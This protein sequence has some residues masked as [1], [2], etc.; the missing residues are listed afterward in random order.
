VENGRQN[1]RK[2][3]IVKNQKDSLKNNIA[4]MEEEKPASEECNIG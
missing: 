2:V 1:T 3:L 4:V